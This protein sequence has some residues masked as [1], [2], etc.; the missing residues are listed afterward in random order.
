MWK[1]VYSY[2]ST[3]LTYPLIYNKRF[4]IAG[5]KVQRNLGFMCKD[6]GEGVRRRYNGRTS[7]TVPVFSICLLF[8]KKILNDF[9][10]RL[11]P[12]DYGWRV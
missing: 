9:Y 3:G 11:E 1:E 4:L 6:G 5:L 12:L 7:V 8:L 2:I 10:S